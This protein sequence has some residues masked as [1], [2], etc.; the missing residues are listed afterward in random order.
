[1][2]EEF[3]TGTATPPPPPPSGGDEIAEAKGTAWLAYLGILFLIPML[4][5][6]ENAFAKFHVKQGIM[7]CLYSLAIV[8]IGS[9]IPII[10]WFLVLPIGGLVIL[11]LAIMGIVKSLAGEYWKAPLG[12]HALAEKWFQF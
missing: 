12:V 6:K 8:I 4:T 5:L 7:L 3:Q 11:V 1:M 2:T 9:V 10:G